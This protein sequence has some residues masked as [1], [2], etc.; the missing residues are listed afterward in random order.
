MILPGYAQVVDSLVEKNLDTS[1][2]IKSCQTP[3]FDDDFVLNTL[4]QDLKIKDFSSNKQ[5]INDEL[6]I[7]IS[8]VKPIEH[9]PVVITDDFLP[10]VSVVQNKKPVSTFKRSAENK[11]IAV[12]LR[13][14]ND[15]TTK[16]QPDE[17]SYLSFETVSDVKLN[18]VVYP[19]GTEVQGRIETVSMN[20]SMGVPADLV[21]GNFLL[22]KMPLDGEI[23]KIGSN[24]SLW[25]YPCVYGGSFFFGAGLLLMPIRG[26]HAKI[27]TDEIFTLYL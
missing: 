23:K 27:K 5:D 26:G 18:N 16:S 9:K 1:L 15:I 21:I 13:I 4:S 12:A 24:R 11:G 6:V 14:K 20:Q 2:T 7:N 22:N 19:A 25:V 8:S 17:G 10:A 3:K